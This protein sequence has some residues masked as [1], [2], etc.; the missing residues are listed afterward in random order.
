MSGESFVVL[1]DIPSI[2]KYVFGTDT[3]N[4]MRGAS[5]KLDRLN[6][7]TMEQHL[8]D[9]LGAAHVE[10]IYANGGSAQFLAHECS[11]LA[12]KTACDGMVRHIREETGGEVRVVYGIASLENE[13]DYPE[14]VRMA[15]FRMRCHREF[16][17][18][19]RSPAL[20]FPAVMKCESA[21]HLPAAHIQSDG[22]G[23]VTG[24]SKAS[25]AKNLQGRE[26]RRDGLWSEWMR[27]LESTGPWP[28][29]EHWGNLR[30]QSLT[31]IGDKSEWRN[32]IGIVYADGNAMGKVVQQLNQPTQLHQFSRII[33]TS[34]RDACFSALTCISESQVDTVRGEALHRNTNCFEPLAADILLLGGDDLLV[35]VPAHHALNFAL[36]VTERFEELAREKIANLPDAETRQFFRDALGDSGTF[37]ISCGVAIAKSSYPFYLSLA[38]AEQLLNNAKRKESQYAQTEPSDNKA[39]IDFHVVAGA[40]SHALQQVREETYQA[41]NEATAPR[42]LRPLTCPQL[43]ALRSSV[44]ELRDAGFPRTKLH[45]L[46]EAA[47]AAEPNEADWRIRD[48]FARCQHGHNRSQRRA[49]WHAVQRLCPDGYTFEFPW[50]QREDRRMLCLADIVEAY[51]LFR[52][53]K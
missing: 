35:A 45:E 37:T 46:Q 22:T 27:H 33:D 19:Y 48:I 39:R 40:N 51:E 13:S 52:E 7:E 1:I 30:C 32:Y 47:L 31:D 10:L 24:L 36:Q 41:G 16:A 42:T 14:A 26:T 25:Y 28:A 29:A 53:R 34:I 3:L 49:L 9:A 44:S 43:A 38:L 17:A 50:F 4:E 2:K 20:R 21:P 6:R 15:H 11:A 23:G 8:C 18:S 12:V 5:A